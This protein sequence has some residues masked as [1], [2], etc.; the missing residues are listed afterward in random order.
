MISAPLTFMVRSNNYAEI[1]TN[2][3]IATGLAQEGLELVTALRNKDLVNFQTI[4]TNCTGVTNGGC[5]IDWDGESDLPTLDSCLD[6]GCQLYTG[7]VDGVETG[8][9]TSG[10]S[11]TDFYRYITLTPNGTLSYTAEAVVYSYVNGIKV[12]VKL[13]KLLTNITIK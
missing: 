5:K 12:E 9:K 13:K 11:V 3:V 8:F 7:N 10:T 6:N 4:A 1:V 2:K